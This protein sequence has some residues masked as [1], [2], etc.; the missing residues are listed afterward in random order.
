MVLM[1]D[2]GGLYCE[3]Q[4]AAVLNVTMGKKSSDSHFD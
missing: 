1:Y 4:G 2:H 3:E